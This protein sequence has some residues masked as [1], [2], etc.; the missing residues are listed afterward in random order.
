MSE[1]CKKIGMGSIESNKE[2]CTDICATTLY[3]MRTGVHVRE[4]YPS[5]DGK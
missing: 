1:R 4:D 3:L 2:H 5:P